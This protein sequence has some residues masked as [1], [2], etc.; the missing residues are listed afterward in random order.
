MSEIS[1]LVEL[2][3]GIKRKIW[4]NVSVESDNVIQL[5]NFHLDGSNLSL[6]LEEDAT[7]LENFLNNISDEKCEALARLLAQYLD[8]NVLCQDKKVSILIRNEGN[9]S[10]ARYV[11]DVMLQLFNIILEKFG[12]LAEASIG[13]VKVRVLGKTVYVLKRRDIE[14]FVFL[15]GSITTVPDFSGWIESNIGRD[16]VML[17]IL[18]WI[19][20]EDEIEIG[21]LTSQRK[22]ESV[23]LTRIADKLSQ[24]SEELGLIGAVSELDLVKKSFLTELLWKIKA[25]QNG[26]QVSTIFQRHR[27]LIEEDILKSLTDD[28]YKLEK[29]LAFND[30]LLNRIA[31][32]VAARAVESGDR[33]QLISM[34]E[35]VLTSN[36][37]KVTRLGGG[38]AVYIGKEELKHI[39]FS[40]RANVRVIKMKDGSKVLVIEPL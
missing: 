28:L 7:I 25:F 40:E 27:V 12:H 14:N 29:A 21:Y 22:L 13:L 11:V 4:K 20:E 33:E 17:P 18:S 15:K 8:I 39:E 6:R 2:E 31:N 10:H 34:G 30:A 37:R 32:R 26:E 16:N 19:N 24:Y 1:N 9:G 35:E 36:I 38:K 23:N 3:E 5:L